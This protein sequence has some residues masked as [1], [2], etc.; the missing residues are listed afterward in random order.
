[1]AGP[2]DYLD[3]FFPE[4]QQAAVDPFDQMMQ[5]Y[6]RRT[7][8]GFG[9]PMV[10]QVG[11]LSPDKYDA[12]NMQRQIENE[13][14]W[15]TTRDKFLLEL[16]QGRQESDINTAQLAQGERRLGLEEREFGQKYGN[17]QDETELMFQMFD[18]VEIQ[19]AFSGSDPQAFQTLGMKMAE[20]M[21]EGVNGTPALT[22]RVLNTMGAMAQDDRAMT[23][24]ALALFQQNEADTQKAVEGFGGFA[25]Q[26]NKTTANPRIGQAVKDLVMGSEDPTLAMGNLGANQGS[27]DKAFAALAMMLQDQKLGTNR[28]AGPPVQE[29]P[30]APP[31]TNPEEG[32]LGPPGKTVSMG[33]VTPRSALE[34]IG[35]VAQRVYTPSIDN[36]FGVAGYTPATYGVRL[37]GRGVRGLTRGFREDVGDWLGVEPTMES[38]SPATYA[39]AGTPG[40][41]PNDPARVAARSGRSTVTP[42]QVKAAQASAAKKAA[43]S[44]AAKKKK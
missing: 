14:D 44:A 16:M 17:T 29:A 31:T 7:Q 22:P 28:F 23:P 13:R 35:R 40:T 21:G 11:A 15:Q 36:P 12:Q 25:G 38:Y 3:Y 1:M 6:M 24:E 37:V 39:P 33:D 19:Q 26:I 8:P 20:L 42:A 43:A 4:Q 34:G 2:N 32:W 10:Q 18:P 30:A 9:D 5:E 27:R 41:G